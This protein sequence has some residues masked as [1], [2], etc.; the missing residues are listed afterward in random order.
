[1]RKREKNTFL[2]DWKSVYRFVVLNNKSFEEKASFKASIL[3]VASIISFV[4]I[5]IVVLTFLVI[6][7]V[8]P[9]KNLVPCKTSSHTEKNLIQLSLQIDSLINVA[10]SQKKYI[11][12]IRVILSDSVNNLGLEEASSI[13]SVNEEDLEISEAERLFQTKITGQDKDSYNLELSSSSLLF[14]PPI[15]GEITQK[16][17]VNE[18]HF[19]VDIVSKKG[20]LINSIQNG[21]VVFSDWTESGGLTICVLHEEGYF[22]VYKHNSKLLKNVGDLVNSGEPISVIGNTGS[23]SSGAHLHFELWKN[24]E[25]I[26]PKNYISF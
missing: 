7:F 24:G 4:F 12:S 16:Y 15:I 19:G 13:V 6:S 22:S 17:S 21:R 18:S 2:F 20:A 26:N 11:N 5:S 25:S 9:I 10:S 23:L 8:D 14:V 3:K 1:M